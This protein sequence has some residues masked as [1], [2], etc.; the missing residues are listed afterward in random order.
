MTPADPSMVFFS[1]NSSK[2]IFT[3]KASSDVRI[4]EDEPP[5]K[6]AFNFLP[7]GIPPALSKIRSLRD[8][9][10]DSSKTPGLLTRPEIQNN[11]GPG[12]FSGPIDLNQLAPRVI[13]WGTQER[14][15]TLFTI[16]GLCK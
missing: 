10:I 8:I 12:P 14:V 13:I 11:L 15:S 6:T 1:V 16:V 4:A 5:G 2:S 3:S 7:S 9:P